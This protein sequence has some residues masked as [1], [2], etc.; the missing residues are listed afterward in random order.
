[1]S[2]IKKIKNG[3][4]VTLEWKGKEYWRHFHYKIEAKEFQKELMKTIA[5]N[6]YTFSPDWMKMEH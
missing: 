6:Q 1:M 5:D 4:A 3:W 2:D